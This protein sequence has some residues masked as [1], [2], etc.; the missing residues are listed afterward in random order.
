MVREDG[1]GN[2]KSAKGGADERRNLLQKYVNTGALV[3]PIVIDIDA[4]SKPFLDL[5]SDII[6]PGF[7]DWEQFGSP[8]G[9]PFR[10]MRTSLSLRQHELIGWILAIHFV[11]AA[12]L[13]A[14]DLVGL[15]VV[16]GR[17]DG[18]LWK[19]HR[20]PPPQSLGLELD[21]N[22]KASSMMHGVLSTEVGEEEPI[23]GEAG[24]VEGHWYMNPIHCRTSFEP[25]VGGR[26]EDS[27]ISGTY[28][29][30]MDPLFPKGPMMYNHGWVLDLGPEAT[31]IER[32]LQQ[33]K[34][35]YVYSTVAY[36]GI[37]P[38]GGLKLFLPYEENESVPTYILEEAE[39]T[40][41]V[42]GGKRRNKAKDGTPIPE[43]VQ[44]ENIVVCGANEHWGDK[45]CNM[46]TDV[47]FIVGG[48]MATE[49]HYID[50]TGVSDGK[51]IC[52]T[53]SV[54]NNATHTTKE[55]MMKE[56][57]TQEQERGKTMKTEDGKS[58][59][60]QS[61]ANETGGGQLEMSSTTGTFGL[62]LHILV[63]GKVFWNDGPCSISHVVWEQ[64]TTDL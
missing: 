25:T 60:Y 33:Y 26:L 19:K 53:M 38:S 30:K 11:S 28:A 54:P 57:N 47:D 39:D 34:L 44:F 31:R 21:G 41:N 27:I 59:R 8:D 2:S 14:V 56:A 29:Q 18:N 15:G 24:S 63:K 48:E 46:E 13:A 37:P 36:Y 52:V 16:G 55:L 49:V 35:G 43:Y 40:N 5:H 9:A 32:M 6:P 50:A 42:G 4:A 64:T 51:R 12:E 61:P 7:T 10:S 62:S 58:I 22:S 17:D 23:S 20:L 1:G 3:D 45:Q